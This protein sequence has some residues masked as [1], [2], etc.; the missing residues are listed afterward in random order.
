MFLPAKNFAASPALVIYKHENS[1]IDAIREAIDV[2]DKSINRSWER[3]LAIDFNH[4]GTIS[5]EGFNPL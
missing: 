2:D 1:W 4:L 5:L 3:F